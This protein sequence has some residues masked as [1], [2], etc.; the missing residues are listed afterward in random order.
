MGQ[1]DLFDENSNSE[2]NYTRKG[3]SNILV[4]KISQILTEIIEDNKETNIQENI[5]NR[6]NFFTKKKPKITILKYLERIIK[7]T[8]IEQGTLISSIIYLDKIANSK[9]IL[10]NENN[11]H[12]YIILLILFR[13]LLTSILISIKFNDD[14]YFDNKFY[15]DV[16]GIELEEI[17]SLEIE[18][19]DLLDWK[20][21][22]DKE[23][24]G[25]YQSYFEKYNINLEEL[26]IKSQLC[27]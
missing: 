7:H 3:S 1:T 8:G 19:L 14:D 10:L 18:L 4:Y 27:F 2:T 9:G 13:F 20:L 5:S 26:C 6:T 21:Y 15:A 23:L 17:N 11:L 22:I 12:R 24:Y 16:G 25:Q